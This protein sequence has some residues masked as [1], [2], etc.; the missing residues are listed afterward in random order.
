MISTEEK[1]ACVCEALKSKGDFAKF[2]ERSKTITGVEAKLN[3]ALVVLKETAGI[4][5]CTTPEGK[6]DLKLATKESF[7]ESGR[8]KKNNGVLDTFVEGDPLRETPRFSYEAVDGNVS[9]RSKTDRLLCE[10]LG[11]TKEQTNKVCGAPDNMPDDLTEGQ[12]EEFRFCRSIGISE[13]DALRVVKITGGYSNNNKR[14][15]GRILEGR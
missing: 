3:C 7:T 5:E 11:F 6:W 12:R 4:V 14:V 9:L 2:T 1:F 13:A 10:S 8:V 15:S